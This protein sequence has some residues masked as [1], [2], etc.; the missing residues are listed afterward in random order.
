MIT[1][2]SPFFPSSELE[3][4]LCSWRK[5][6]LNNEKLDSMEKV[7]L[8]KTNKNTMHSRY[9]KAIYAERL[10]TKIRNANYVIQ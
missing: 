3:E 4:V 9:F 10:L 8:I 5:V 7:G 1:I 6:T 2:G